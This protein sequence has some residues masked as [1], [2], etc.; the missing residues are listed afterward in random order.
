MLRWCY[1]VF[2]VL[3]WQIKKTL[4]TQIFNTLQ[5]YNYTEL[6]KSNYMHVYCITER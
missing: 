1:I 6:S 4:F 2:N 5:L 3:L